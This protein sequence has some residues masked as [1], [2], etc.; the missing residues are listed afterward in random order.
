MTKPVRSAVLSSRLP[1]SPAARAGAARVKRCLHHRGAAQDHARRKGVVQADTGALRLSRR[2][3]PLAK[4][5]CTH[6]WSV[7]E[8]PAGTLYTGTGEEGKVFKVTAGGKVSLAYNAEASQ[9][10]CLVADGNDE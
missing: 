2:L 4:P 6:V 1:L 9:V 5:D 10:L 3:N 7:V 8:D